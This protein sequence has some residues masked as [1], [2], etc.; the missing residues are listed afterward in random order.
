ME[1]GLQTRLRQVLP[2]CQFHV[3]HGFAKIQIWDRVSISTKNHDERTFPRSTCCVRVFCC[4]MSQLCRGMTPTYHRAALNETPF[5][6]KCCQARF[7]VFQAKTRGRRA[8]Q[9]A[10]DTSPPQKEQEFVLLPTA[11]FANPAVQT[12]FVSSTSVSRQLHHRRLL[13]ELLLHVT[14]LPPVSADSNAWI[15]ETCLVL[16][17]ATT[18]SLQ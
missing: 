7:L 9:S 5:E 16:C 1:H 17:L 11:N 12:K 8:S 18:R 6:R 10:V 13:L 4:N 3:L 2:T 14:I 15:S